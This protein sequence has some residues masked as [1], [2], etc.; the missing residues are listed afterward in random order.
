[1]L[2]TAFEEAMR[3]GLVL[4]NVADLVD[5][6]RK[7][8]R[9]MAVYDEDHARM[10][11]AAAPG[12]RFEAFCVL[13]LAT[14]M[15]EGELLALCWG[16]VSLEKATVTVLAT[17]QQYPGQRLSREETKTTHSTRVIALPQTV[18]SALIQH[19]QV[20]QEEQARVGAAWNASE[21]GFPNTIGAPMH[22][23]AFR[24]RWWRALVT[25]AGL[26]HTRFHDLRSTAAT[27]LL[28]RGAP[29]NWGAPVK[30]VSEMLGHA[31]VSITLNMHGYVLPHR[32]PQAAQTMHTILTGEA[33][34]G[35]HEGSKSSSTDE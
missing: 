17:L 10:L 21:L 29:V 4:R 31:N 24:K 9:K 5:P 8:R 7:P 11:I 28:G 25:K 19:H 12:D 13:V 32:Q 16:E 30:V 2:Y 26:P 20:Q 15:R 35:L 18:V 34:K 3:F 22:A 27:L 14:G 1:V 6:P 33:S 23:S